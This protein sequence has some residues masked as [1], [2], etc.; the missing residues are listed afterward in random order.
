MMT[1]ESERK[2]S[3]KGSGRFGLHPGLW[4]LGL[5]LLLAVFAGGRLWCNWVCPAGTLFS[6][7]STFSWRKDKVDRKAGCT[8]CGRCFAK[9]PAGGARKEDGR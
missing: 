4:L 2:W 8:G 9:A 3:G 6:L 1:S 7:L 5:L